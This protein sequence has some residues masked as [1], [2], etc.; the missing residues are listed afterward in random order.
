MNFVEYLNYL[1]DI[2]LSYADHRRRV[3]FFFSECVGGNVDP[4]IKDLDKLIEK[5]IKEFDKTDWVSVSYILSKAYFSK[6]LKEVEKNEQ[7]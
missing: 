2:G 5:P 4:I 3:L 1:I 6:H 7:N